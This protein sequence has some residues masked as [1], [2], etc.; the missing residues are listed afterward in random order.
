M[1]IQV[2]ICICKYLHNIHVYIYIY[3]LHIYVYVCGQPKYRHIYNYCS[4]I[5]EGQYGKPSTDS[6]SSSA[7]IIRHRFFRWGVVPKMSQNV[8]AT[9]F[10]VCPS[11]GP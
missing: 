8:R 5:N 2:C 4:N 7:Y 1:Y 6:S 10:K 9:S 3:I 11:G